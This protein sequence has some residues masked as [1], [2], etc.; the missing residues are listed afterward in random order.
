MGRDTKNFR[1]TKNAR[2]ADNSA[3]NY[4]RINREGSWKIFNIFKK[5]GK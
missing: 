4:S 5:G 2:S 3:K 1:Q